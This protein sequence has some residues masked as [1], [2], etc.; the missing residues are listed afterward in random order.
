M[1]RP[2]QYALLYYMTIKGV[3]WGKLLF[4]DVYGALEPMQNYRQNPRITL[5]MT[6]SERPKLDTMNKGGIEP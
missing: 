1:K 6:V 2:T 5:L 4:D 3:T